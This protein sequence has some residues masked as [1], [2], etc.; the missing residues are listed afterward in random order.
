MN[1]KQA[2]Q[3]NLPDLMDKM[4]YQ[5]TAV[6]KGGNEY[7]YRSPFREEKEASFHTSFLGGKW[8]WKDFG[9]RGGTVIDFVMRHEGFNG[10]GEALSYLDRLYTGMSLKITPEVQNPLNQNNLFSFQQQSPPQ[11]EKN[12]SVCAAPEENSEIKFIDAF[13]IRSKA[14]LTYLTKERAI[15]QALVERYLVE[16]TYR[17]KKSDKEYFAFGMEN[18]AGGYEIRAASDEY[19]FKSV[20]NGRDITFIK[21]GGTIPR[22]V[23]VFEGMTDFLSLL[24]MMGTEQSRGDVIVMHSLSSFQRTIDFIKKGGYEEVNLFL[25]NDKAGKEHTQRFADMLGEGVKSQHDFYQGYKDLNECLI[26]NQ[27]SNYLLK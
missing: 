3:I 13:P 4:G 1:S 25:D 17:H 7:W 22:P 12:F 15:S 16:V 14:I 9:D 2:K 8:I 23:N 27:E 21:G 24:A 11:A 10:V 19:S 18:M 26:H 5:P 6:K 20:V